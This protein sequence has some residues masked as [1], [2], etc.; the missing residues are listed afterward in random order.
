MKPKYPNTLALAIAEIKTLRAAKEEKDIDA[1]KWRE[2][3]NAEYHARQKAQ[4]QAK[5]AQE[6]FADLKRRLHDSEMAVARLNG[7]M[8]RVREDDAVSDPLVEV[9]G[10]HGKRLVSKRYP[11]SDHQ[12]PSPSDYCMQE[13]ALNGRKPHWTSY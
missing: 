13:M 10:P 5:E 8:E 6:Q 11:H 9:D 12:Q 2:R 4:D 7:Y 1:N 3:F